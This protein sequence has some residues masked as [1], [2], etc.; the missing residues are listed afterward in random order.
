MPR[1]GDRWPANS[2]AAMQKLRNAQLHLV[3]QN[4]K[5]SMIDAWKFDTTRADRYACEI[6]EA[7]QALINLTNPRVYR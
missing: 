1:T 6:L 3:E 4:P 5:C 7:L 2:A